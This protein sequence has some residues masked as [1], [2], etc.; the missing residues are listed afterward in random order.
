MS[1]LQRVT[2]LAIVVV[3]YYSLHCKVRVVI[4]KKVTSSHESKGQGD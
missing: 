2:K 1:L 3:S 4:L